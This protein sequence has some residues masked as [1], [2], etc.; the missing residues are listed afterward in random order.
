MNEEISK[1]MPLV[2]S[3]TLPKEFMDVNGS[4]FDESNFKEVVNL[5]NFLTA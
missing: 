5:W 2:S 1:P 3:Y 4:E